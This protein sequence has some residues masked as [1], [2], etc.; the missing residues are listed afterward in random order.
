MVLAYESIWSRTS[1]DGRPWNLHTFSKVN[2]QSV[3]SQWGKQDAVFTC[4]T[5]IIYKFCLPGAM[6]QAAMSSPD[7]ISLYFF[8]SLS[9]IISHLLYFKRITYLQY[10]K[11]IFTFLFMI[12]FSF[13]WCWVI[14]LMTF[15]N[16]NLPYQVRSTHPYQQVAELEAMRKAGAPPSGVHTFDEATKW[17]VSIFG[18]GEIVSMISLK[19]RGVQLSHSH[20]IVRQRPQNGWLDKTFNQ[21][22][23]QKNFR[24]HGQLGL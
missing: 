14:S 12:I 21:F 24:K 22:L 1:L 11:I 4:P 17:N 20:S 15:Q 7:Y 6:G 8:W 2:I 5:A 10:G 13:P 9:V 3:L 19:S 18:G 16:D 23:T